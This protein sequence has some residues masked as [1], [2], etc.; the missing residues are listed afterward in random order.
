MIDIDHFCTI[1]KKKSLPMV[2]RCNALLSLRVSLRIIDFYP[3]SLLC[4]HKIE[5]KSIW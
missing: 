2:L 5:V 1:S 4:V 3:I